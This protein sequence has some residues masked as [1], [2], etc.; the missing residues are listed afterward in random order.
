MSGGQT[1]VADAT[2][3]LFANADNSQIAAADPTGSDG[4]FAFPAQTTNGNPLDI[5]VGITRDTDRPSFVFPPRPLVA[6]QTGIPAVLV[7]DT[8]LSSLC[9]TMVAPSGRGQRHDPRDRLRLP[10]RR[11][12]PVRS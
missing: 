4:A 8:T 9:S 6:D 2:A 7:S 12:S 3:T 10:E 5:Y 11:S 1:L